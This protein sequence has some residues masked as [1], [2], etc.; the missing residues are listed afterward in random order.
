MSLTMSQ[1][2]EES[3]MLQNMLLTPLERA[4]L[5]LLVSGYALEEAAPAVGLSLSEAKALL[6]ELQRRCGVSGFNRL[7]VLAIL[8]AWV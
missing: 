8:N 5:R 6:E 2:R 3:R 1:T 4:L 7:I